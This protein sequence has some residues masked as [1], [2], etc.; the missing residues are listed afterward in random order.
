[1]NTE[2]VVFILGQIVYMR[3]NQDMEGM[4]TGI[5]FRPSGVTYEVTWSDFEERVHFECELVTEKTFNES[6]K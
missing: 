1:M 2:K 4:V 5:T 3:I 6:K